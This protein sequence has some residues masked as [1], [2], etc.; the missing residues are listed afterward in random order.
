ME[1]TNAFR[2]FL[3][4]YKTACE[5]TEELYQARINLGVPLEL[6]LSTKND[7]HAASS[8][9]ESLDHK[10]TVRLPPDGGWDWEE[11]YDS[12][13]KNTKQYCVS[14]KSDGEL[15]GILMGGVSKGKQVVS[16]SYIEAANYHTAL[17]SSV[18]DIAM[19]FSTLVALN[20]EIRASY[21]AVY[22]PNEAMKARLLEPHLG[23]FEKNLFGYRVRKGVGRPLYKD[24]SKLLTSK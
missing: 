4:I 12:Q 9:G 11:I 5:Q 8:W 1:V 10:G 6:S 2:R 14:F 3:T 22:E 24:I 15:G 13:R 17:S 16:I 23:F 20:S 7:I 18:V 19:S 21:L